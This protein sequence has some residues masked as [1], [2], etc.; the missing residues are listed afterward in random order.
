MGRIGVVLLLA[1]GGG[2]AG[3]AGAAQAQNLLLNTERQ[4]YVQGFAGVTFAHGVAVSDSIPPDLPYD[5]TFD[6]GFSVGGAVG[7]A[8]DS[9][10]RLEAEAAYRLNGPNEVCFIGICADP[11]SLVGGGADGELGVFT[12]MVNALFDFDTG[13]PVTP[14]LG[15]GLGIGNV[16]YDV[17]FAGASYGADAWGAALQVIAGLSYQISPELALFADYRFLTVFDSDVSAPYPPGGYTVAVTD[18]YRAHSV[19]VGLRYLFG[20]DSGAPAASTISPGPEHA[21]VAMAEPEA[22]LQR[23][24]I[25]FDEGGADLDSDARAVIAQAVDRFEQAGFVRLFAQGTSDVFGSAPVDLALRRAD[26]IRRDLIDRGVTA[27]GIVVRAFGS[28]EVLL[29]PAGGVPEPGLPR[30]EVILI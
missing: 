16:D 1:G 13:S 24:I 8:F 29:A 27:S 28:E 5:V 7:V 10:L 4:W 2:V 26:A 19:L 30:V 23:L 11:A 6:P 25:V 3:I 14:Y 20:A 9:G 17:T 18:D 12:L 21:A 22:P 15:A